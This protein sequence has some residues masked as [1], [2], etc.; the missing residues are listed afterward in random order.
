MK[1]RCAVL[2][3]RRNLRFLAGRKRRPHC[4]LLPKRRKLGQPAMLELMES[5]GAILPELQLA[6]APLVAGARNTAAALEQAAGQRR[7]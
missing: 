7:L 4:F 2:D 5:T 6:T 3:W 1:A